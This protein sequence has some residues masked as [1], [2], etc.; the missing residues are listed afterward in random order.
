MS[1]EVR[2]DRRGLGT[3]PWAIVLSAVATAAV[4]IYNLASAGR[5]QNQTLW[6]SQSLYFVFSVALVVGIGFVDSRFIMRM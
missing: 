3:I 2:I 5:G 6:E 4:G 1:A